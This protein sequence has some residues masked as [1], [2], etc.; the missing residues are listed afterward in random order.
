MSTVQ[1]DMKADCARTQHVHP[2]RL[3]WTIESL[4]FI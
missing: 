3:K 2:Q 4:L 1:T